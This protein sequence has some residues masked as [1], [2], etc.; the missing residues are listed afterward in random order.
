MH[1]KR[2]LRTDRNAERCRKLEID[3]ERQLSAIRTS[4]DGGLSHQDDRSKRKSSMAGTDLVCT[5]TWCRKGVEHK[6]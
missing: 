1:G 4:T 5:G 6:L 3:V 2:G